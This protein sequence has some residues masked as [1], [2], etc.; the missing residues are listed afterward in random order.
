MGKFGE[1]CRVGGDVDGR[2]ENEGEGEDEF[3]AVVVGRRQ[4]LRV[5]EDDVRCG[6]GRQKRW[7]EGDEVAAEGLAGNDETGDGGKGDEGGV[8]RGRDGGGCR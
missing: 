6:V 7:C 8:V 2:A 5:G 1:D 3:I 4:A